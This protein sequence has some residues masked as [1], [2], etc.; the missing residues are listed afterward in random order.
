M[1]IFVPMGLNKISENLKRIDLN[2]P[3]DSLK[4]IYSQDILDA[5]KDSWEDKYMWDEFSYLYAPS[6][7]AEKFLETFN[8]KKIDWKYPDLEWKNIVD[9]GSGFGSLAF[10]L[11]LSKVKLS[12]VDPVFAT[13]IENKIKLLDK[14]ISKIEKDIFKSKELIEN[15]YIEIDNFYKEHENDL[16]NKWR[17]IFANGIAEANKKTEI[18]G[19]IKSMNNERAKLKD[20]LQKRINLLPHQSENLE[21]HG[22]IWENIS[23]IPD[24]SQDFVFIS[25]VLDKDCVQP[26]LILS[27]ASRILRPE[28]KIYMIH[29]Y[30]KHLLYFFNKYSIPYREENWRYI[31]V[32]SKKI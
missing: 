10:E 26:E 24:T 21:L 1:T 15:K 6:T 25:C 7:S 17:S 13:S 30:H 22:T 9:I 8:F 18:I 12:L 4:C 16:S 19:K 27:E 20:D 3:L 32:I 2:I 5:V 28:W 31:S 23:T 11:M 14:H 29:D